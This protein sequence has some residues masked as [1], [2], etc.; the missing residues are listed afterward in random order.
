MCVYGIFAYFQGLVISNSLEVLSPTNFWG[1]LFWCFIGLMFISGIIVEKIPSDNR[2]D[3]QRY[4]ER[5]QEICRQRKEEL[6]LKL[7]A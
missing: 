2:T 5:C 7:Y 6:K 3:R 4:E 1:L